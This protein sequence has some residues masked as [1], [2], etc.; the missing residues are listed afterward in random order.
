MDAQELAVA[1]VAGVTG[2]GTLGGALAWAFREK[3]EKWVDERIDRA[4]TP[5]LREWGEWRGEMEDRM[6]AQERQAALVAQSLASIA[7]KVG[8]GVER[9]TVTMQALSG[10]VTAQG[11]LLAEQGAIIVSLDKTIERRNKRRDDD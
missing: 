11:K 6:A 3:A 5:T 8:E 2:A 9:L 7:E 10:E 1:I 4:R